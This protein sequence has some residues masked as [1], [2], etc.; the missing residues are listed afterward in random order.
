MNYRQLCEHRAPV[1]T[2]LDFFESLHWP[3]EAFV[4]PIGHS[5]YRQSFGAPP[6]SAELGI[7]DGMNNCHMTESWTSVL[8]RSINPHVPRLSSGMPIVNPYVSLRLPLEVQPSMQQTSIDDSYSHRTQKA[9]ASWRNFQV[10]KPINRH[11]VDPNCD[12]SGEEKV[13]SQKRL[14]QRLKCFDDS[15]VVI[16]EEKIQTSV[17]FQ[18]KNKR[19]DFKINFRRENRKVDGCF[20]NDESKSPVGAMSNV[21]VPPPK[22]KWIRH[23]MTGKILTNF[24]RTAR[25]DCR[26][27]EVFIRKASF[28]GYAFHEKTLLSNSLRTDPGCDV[29]MQSHG[30]FSE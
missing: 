4:P 27:W 26:F 13:S 20:H 24:V 30:L 2:H 28:K 11:P 17:K 16:N 25:G 3:R 8:E 29:V 23:Y 19:V 5:F 15:E 1:R 10:S 12:N 22:K 7:C 21:A 6:N 9:C 18:D 14:A